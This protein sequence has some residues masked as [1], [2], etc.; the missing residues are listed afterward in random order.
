MKTKEVISMPRVNRIKTDYPGVYYIMGEGARGPERIYYIMYRRDGKL[1]EEKAGRQFQ[2]DMTPAKAS[3]LRAQR[4]DKKDIPNKEKRA[5]EKKE[6]EAQAGKW[7][8]D[9]LWGHYQ[10]NRGDGVKGLQTDIYRYDKF[11]KTLLGS[12]EP[13]NVIDLDIKRLKHSASMKKSSPQTQ[14]HVYNLLIRISNYGMKESLCPGLSVKIEKP[15]VSNERAE[16]LTAEQIKQVVEVLNADTNPIA[17]ALLFALYTGCR[18]SEVLRLPWS[19]IDF[20]N[21][22]ILITHRKGRKGG[23]YGKDLNIHMAPAVRDLLLSIPHTGDLVFAGEKG[24]ERSQTRHVTKRMKK[25]A[26]LPDEFRPWHGLRHNFASML[27][28]QGESLYMVQSL[29]GHSNPS[30]TKRYSHMTE[31][32]LNQASEKAASLIDEASKAKRQESKKPEQ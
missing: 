9:K 11:L 15:E 20:D 19:N 22:R 26:S 2:D 5:Q 1:I 23:K 13:K 7:T 8:F 16:S 6:K 24:R 32:A 29:L 28:S 12:K 4:I 21:N 25:A 17:K 18:K 30:T 31:K 27:V 3:G 10:E 14:K